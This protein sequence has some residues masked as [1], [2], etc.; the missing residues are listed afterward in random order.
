ML[1]YNE[2]TE[3]LMEIAMMLEQL[4]GENEYLFEVLTDIDS[5]TWKQKFVNWANEF[6]ETYEPNRDVWPGN[7]LEV[8]ERFAREKILEFAGVGERE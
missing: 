3:N 5:I 8:I 7:Y 6:T 2:Q 4:K 1:E